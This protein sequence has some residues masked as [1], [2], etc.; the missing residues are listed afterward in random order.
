MS[1]LS[2]AKSVALS[3]AFEKIERLEAEMS[4]MAKT[5]AGLKQ[6]I[7]PYRYPSTR[8]FQ[9]VMGITPL[10]AGK[11]TS[12]HCLNTLRA[13]K[14]EASELGVTPQRLCKTLAGVGLWSRLHEVSYVS[15]KWG[16]GMIERYGESVSAKG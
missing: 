15:T 3:D 2:R 10:S 14:K 7:A 11:P 16:Q 8:N 4:V 6:T 13:L 9:P 12:I 1:K 5:L